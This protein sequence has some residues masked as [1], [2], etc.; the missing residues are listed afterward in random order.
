MKTGCFFTYGGPGRISI[1]RFVPRD[2]PDGYRVFKQLAPRRWFNSASHDEFEETFDRHLRTLD[3]LKIWIELH[4]LAG[5]AAAREP[6]AGASSLPEPVLLCWER[7]PLDHSN[8]CHRR[9]VARWFH[10]TLGKDVAEL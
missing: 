9:S 2:I 1:A 7:P 4:E 3:P 6:A 5:V 10:D 8:W